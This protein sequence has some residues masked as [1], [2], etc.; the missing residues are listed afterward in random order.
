[1]PGYRRPARHDDPWWPWER[2]RLGLSGLLRGRLGR[3][4]I[5]IAGIL[6]FSLASLLGGF[7]TDQARLLAARVIQ[8]AGGAM[9]V[10]AALSLIAVTFPRAR[11]GTARWACTR[12]LVFCWC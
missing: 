7:A 1:V 2:P 4:R 6:V 5:F 9:A 12:R 10:P 8:G 11:S 3:R